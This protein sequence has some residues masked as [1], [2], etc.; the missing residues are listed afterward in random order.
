LSKNILIIVG[1]T[2]SGKSA[3]A[4]DLAE[5][6]EGAV[7]N[8]DSQQIYR[9]LS[10]LSARPSENEYRNVPYKL[11]GLYSAEKN[12]CTAGEWRQLAL[13]EIKNSKEKNQLPIIVGGTGFYIF[14]LLNGI[15]PVP[16]V[17]E[18]IRRDTEDLLNTMGIE[19]FYKELCIRDS[20]IARK[21]KPTDK[22]RLLRAWEVLEATGKSLAYWQSIPADTS[23]IAAYN[24]VTVLLAP[25]RKELYD[26]INAR[27]L[28]MI[29]QGAVE[30]VKGLERIPDAHP[31]TKAV[32]VKEIRAFLK[33]ATS[34]EEAIEEMQKETRRYAKR[35]YTWFRHQLQPSLVIPNAY[36]QK[37]RKGSQKTRN[38]IKELL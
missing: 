14:T 17:S 34:L 33:G 28:S 31:V 8:A 25:E 20:Q 36:I 3:L 15:S 22:R 9:E 23:D 24:F 27:V 11:F 37:D 32:G 30:E 4:H 35:Q 18:K 6:L 21:L 26:S 12:T 16:E 29:E 19:A 2:G 5:E 1:P 38:E 10:V 7:L 13:R